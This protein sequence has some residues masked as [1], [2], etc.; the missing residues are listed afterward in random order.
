MVKVPY[1]RYI[2]DLWPSTPLARYLCVM[3]NFS[4]TSNESLYHVSFLCIF[5]VNR[6]IAT[7]NIS[8]WAWSCCWTPS[9]PRSVRA[10]WGC[11][12]P[13]V[14]AWVWSNDGRTISSPGDAPSR[15]ARA[16]QWMS[17]RFMLDWL[18][19]SKSSLCSLAMAVKLGRHQ[20]LC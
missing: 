1:S 19:L 2:N 10:S 7:R 13:L 6:F 17:A 14:P 20:R 16:V 11:H 3:A 9:H 4:P 8:G 5:G 15:G 12:S 18:S